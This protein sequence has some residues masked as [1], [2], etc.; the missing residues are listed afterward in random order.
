MSSEKAW[1]ELPVLRH[2]ETCIVMG[3]GPSLNAVPRPFLYRHD[4]IGTNGIYLKFVPEF[5]VAVN[6]LVIGQFLA[7]IKTLDSTAKFIGG[8]FA[9]RVPGSFALISKSMAHFAREPWRGIY[10]GYT[11]TYVALEIAFFLGYRTAL[12]VGVDHRYKFEGAPNEEHVLEGDDPNHFDPRYFK[13]LRWN[14]PDLERSEQS[15]RMARTVW[16]QDGRRI[17]NLGP[18]SALDVFERGKLEDWS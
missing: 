12:L 15:Y 1:R 2:G 18:D 13:G 17:V 14:N 10:E 7:D 8:G 6:P 5:Y 4:T 16:E 11:V 9:G 3:N